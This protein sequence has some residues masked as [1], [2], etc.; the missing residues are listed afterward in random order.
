ME[1][2]LV[3]LTIQNV[4]LL[5][6]NFKSMDASDLFSIPKVSLFEKG[7]KTISILPISSSEFWL[8]VF[9]FIVVVT[10][11]LLIIREIRCWYW[12]IN[13][14]TELLFAIEEELEE[15][16]EILKNKDKVDND[17]KVEENYPNQFKKT[18]I[19]Q[20]ATTE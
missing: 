14:R 10:I 8:F 13:I 5:K 19:D 17:K 15:I 6:I 3:V 20:K 7:E 12:K 1:T 11:L 16:K 4:N 18:S 2:F 9:A